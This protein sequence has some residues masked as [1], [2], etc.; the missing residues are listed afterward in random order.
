[1]ARKNSK[2]PGKT[3]ADTPGKATAAVIE[4][5]T[6][7]YNMEIETVMNYIAASNNLDGALAA[8]IK[9]ALAADVPAELGHAQILARRIKTLGGAVPGSIALEWTQKTLQPPEDTTDLLAVVDGVIDAER[10]AIEQYQKIIEMCAS[11]D[12]P[13]QDLASENLADEQEHLREFLGFRKE[14]EKILRE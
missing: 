5:L 3:R 12:Q 4:A 9:A 10:G 1:M 6:V 2:S 13:T 11:G 14:L 7:S 8:P